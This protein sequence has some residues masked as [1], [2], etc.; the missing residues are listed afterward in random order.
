MNSQWQVLTNQGN[1]MML[2]RRDFLTT[3]V[4]ATS[5]LLA[6]GTLLA[7]S[8][9]GTRGVL[10]AFSTPAYIEDLKH[11]PELQAALNQ[12]WNDNCNGWTEQAILG[13]PWTSLFQAFQDYYYNPLTTDLSNGVQAMV[14]WPAFPNRIS[15][16]YEDNHFPYFDSSDP[17]TGLTSAEQQQMA[18]LGTVAG[19]TMGNIL[20]GCACNP[21]PADPGI[22]PAAVPPLL[23]GDDRT[24]YSCGGSDVR[25]VAYAP[26]GPRGWLDEYCEMAKLL[27]ENGRIQ[28]IHFTCENPEYWHTLW[29]VDPDR[30]VE[31]YRE[32]LQNDRVV[33]NDLV[34]HDK[35]GIPVIDPSTGR[36]TYNPLN[37]WNSGMDLR[38]ANPLADRGTVMSATAGGAMHLTSTPNTL[39]TEL[40]LASGSTVQRD[41]ANS[42]ANASELICVAQYGQINRNSDPH[43]GQIGNQVVG[44]QYRISLA[45]PIG[46]YI[47]MPD[48]SSW[49]LPGD[50]GI[51]ADARPEELWHI[52]RGQ[53]HLPGF[54][55][56]MNFLLHVRLEVPK[57][58]K[59]SGAD[60]DLCVSDMMING[61]PI[62]NA[63]QVMQTFNVALFPL[64]LKADRPAPKQPGVIS[65]NPMGAFPQQIMYANVWDAYYGTTYT[66][67]WR[68]SWD[69]QPITMNLASN[70]VIVAPNVHVK[71]G[72]AKTVHLVLTGTNF[73]EVKGTLPTVAF[74]RHDSV[75]PNNPAGEVD[76]TIAVKVT[77]LENVNYTVPGNS[78]PGEQSLLRLEVSLSAD[79]VPG[80]RDLRVEN[81][82]WEGATPAAARWF[83]Q[84]VRTA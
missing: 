77:A 51:P 66:V 13:N 70:S 12:A 46:L 34:L 37:K 81:P 39:Q 50:R 82:D 15:F 49:T 80:V 8:A 33:L 83:L 26:F 43:I 54:A 62:V 38:S 10:K 25:A 27:D 6:P 35:D 71:E 4:A 73:T 63:S 30:V 52:V 68:R 65:A 1:E 75:T 84:V 78:A 76:D 60:P 45:N 53:K 74:I 20:Q 31:L 9:G 24:T 40:Q 61:A 18:D 14:T 36:K 7:Q 21:Y 5:I 55:P 11:K 22:A 64:A 28:K 3:T 47:Q 17:G 32:T 56:S 42:N 29:N 2:G 57:R 67:P 69:N 58:W 44:L 19:R 48:F 16:Y 72:E 59:D 79:T 23:S 41:L